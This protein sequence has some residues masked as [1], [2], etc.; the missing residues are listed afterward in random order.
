[1]K[2]KL[3]HRAFKGYEIVLSSAGAGIVRRISTSSI[4][5]GSIMIDNTSQ[6]RMDADVTLVVPEVNS[7]RCRKNHKG[8]IANPN[9][10]TIQLVMALKPLHDSNPIK[11]E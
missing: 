5:N 2:W 11:K 9:C 3:Q 1:M 6:F 7:E 10:S 4:K 8:I